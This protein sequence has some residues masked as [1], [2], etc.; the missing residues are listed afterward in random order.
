MVQIIPKTP[1]LLDMLGQG[2]AQGFGQSLQQRE[3]MALQ[4]QMADR[5]RQQK[6]QAIRGGLSE[7]MNNP[8]MQKAPLNQQVSGLYKALAEYPEIAKEISGGLRVTEKQNM[9]P[10]D[11]PEPYKNLYMK[12]TPGGKTKIMDMFLQDLQ[13]GTTS[14]GPQEEMGTVPGEE[15]EERPEIKAVKPIDFDRGLTPKER[16]RRQED[17]YKVQTPMVNERRGALASA[18]KSSLSIQRLDQLNESG[19]LPEGFGRLNVNP[20]SGELFLPT[21]ANE[22][23]QLFV[24]TVNDFTV[25]AKDSFGSRVTNFDLQRFMARLPSLAN[26]KEGRSLILKQMEIVNELSQEKE[27]ELLDVV[28]EYGVRNIDFEKAESIAEKRFAPKKKELVQRY[29]DLDGLMGQADKEAASEAKKSAP[30]GHMLMKTAKGDL[31][32]V[33]ND[34]V[35]FYKSKKWVLQ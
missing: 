20:K 13:R 3:Q 32:Y 22:E 9:T 33:P 34:K 30:E 24:K 21:G 8:E 29:K 28:D 17:R 4:Q 25:Q 15:I 27:K 6:A 5:Q 14:L 7:W 11:L 31:R 10:D 19:K 26:T 16:V 1:G 23:T 18:E 35:N 2:M 12:A